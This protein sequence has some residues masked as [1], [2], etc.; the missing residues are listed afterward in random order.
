MQMKYVDHLP[1]G[2]AF[3]AMELYLHALRDKFHPYFRL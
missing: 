2:L 1:T 3:R